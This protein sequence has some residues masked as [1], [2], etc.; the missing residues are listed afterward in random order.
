MSTPI[1]ATYAHDEKKTKIAVENKDDEFFKADAEAALAKPPT[2]PANDNGTSANGEKKMSKSAMKKA[3]KQK[4]MG[5]SKKDKSAL[6]AAW[7]QPKDGKSKKDKAKEGKA[8]KAV[9]FTFTDPTPPGAKKLVNEIEMPDAYHPS[10]VESSW[11]KWWEESGFYSCDPVEAAKRKK[12][13]KFVMVIPPPNVT[14]SL[15]LGHALTAAVEDTLV[16]WHRMCGHSTM[17]VPGTDHAGIATQSV[18]EKKLK[19]E[20]DITRHDLGREKFV[21]KVW[22]WKTEYGNKITNQLRYLG[23]S[24]DWSRERFTVSWPIVWK[25]RG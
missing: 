17:Y 24:V 21:E 8:S 22:E 25:G 6:K 3:A 14:G 12:D 2:P 23:S 15:H 13:D 9:K 4:A 20:K 7:G 11:Q 10:Y 1:D 18:V 5:G 19:K 16:R